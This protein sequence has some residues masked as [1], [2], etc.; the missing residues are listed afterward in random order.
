MR[1]VYF[2]FEEETQ[3]WILRY[4]KWKSHLSLWRGLIHP[5]LLR[6][7]FKAELRER[8]T[9][10][11]KQRGIHLFSDYLSKTSPDSERVLLSDR[12]HCLIYSSGTWLTLLLP[13]GSSY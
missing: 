13:S 7:S 2:E 10:F 11:A 3:T 5:E 6:K 1:A 12:E 8:R 9:S 4:I